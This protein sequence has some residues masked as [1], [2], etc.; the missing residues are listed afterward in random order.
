MQFRIEQASGRAVYQQIIDQVKRDIA[1]GKVR[2]Y[3]NEAG[4]GGIYRKF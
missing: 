2:D 3:H 4:S 1:L